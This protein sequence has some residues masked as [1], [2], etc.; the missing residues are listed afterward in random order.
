MS[1]SPLDCTRCNDPMADLEV[2]GRYT[3]CKACR[4]E[5]EEPDEFDLAETMGYPG[6]D[7][8]QALRA[9]LRLTLRQPLPSDPPEGWEGVATSRIDRIAELARQALTARTLGDRS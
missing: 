4:A 8:A 1:L 2:H 5:V 3:L 6:Q 7:E 9:I